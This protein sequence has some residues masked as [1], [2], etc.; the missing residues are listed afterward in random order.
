M[1]PFSGKAFLRGLH[2]LD[3]HSRELFR[4]HG[5][6]T[7]G[8]WSLVEQIVDDAMLRMLGPDGMEALDARDGDL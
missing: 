6:H 2:H 3:T 8:R 4:R 7:D 5:K 1:A